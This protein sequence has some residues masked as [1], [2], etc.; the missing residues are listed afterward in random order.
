[1]TYLQEGTKE[2]PC[3]VIVDI[4][5]NKLGFL[6]DPGVPREKPPKLGLDQSHKVNIRSLCY[7]SSCQV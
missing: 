7:T 5:E 1:L 4:A 2:E 6:I 3:K